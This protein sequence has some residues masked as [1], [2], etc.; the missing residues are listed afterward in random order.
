MYISPGCHYCFVLLQN[1]ISLL[2]SVAF[3]LETQQW[4]KILKVEKKLS[5]PRDSVLRIRHSQLIRQFAE[6]ALSKSQTF[7][8]NVVG[9][10]K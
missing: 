9:N 1:S 2:T 4:K 7:I 5:Y 10:E 8:K 3:Y 6:M